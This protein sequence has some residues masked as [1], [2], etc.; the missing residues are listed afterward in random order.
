[1][2]TSIQYDPSVQV[3]RDHV[4]YLTP[5][6]ADVQQGFLLTTYIDAESVN[7]Q[8]QTL[9]GSLLE[10]NYTLTACPIVIQTA[11]SN[12][13]VYVFKIK[14]TDI[15]VFLIQILNDNGTFTNNYYNIDGSIYIGDTTNLILVGINLSYSSPTIFCHNGT[16]T[17]SRTDVWDAD[18][19]LVAVIWQN[20]L[21]AIIPE[22]TGGNLQAGS[23]N[24]PLD[25]E[26]I[27]Q[28]DNQLN[29]DGSPSGRYCPIIN[30]L[31]F[32]NNGVVIY[33]AIKLKNGTNYVPVGEISSEPLPPPVIT[34]IKK[35]TQNQEF[36][37]PE[38]TQSVALTVVYANTSNQ[39]EVFSPASNT[40]EFLDRIRFHMYWTV[41]E[42]GKFNSGRIRANRNSIAMVTWTERARMVQIEGGLNPLDGLIPVP[43]ILTES[44]N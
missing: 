35:L 42:A 28:F 7:T 5:G 10:T 23:C 33:N 24:L 22:P 17:I 30:V 18:R 21:G 37:P 39:I 36:I 26:L 38:T 15:L 1:L 13:Q 2:A 27:L 43:G 31:L 41:D 19:N 40:S 25:T 4:C 3:V 12:K 6:S 11:I 8:L 14:N 20:T 29:P 34:G 44:D 9:D 16:D 32:N